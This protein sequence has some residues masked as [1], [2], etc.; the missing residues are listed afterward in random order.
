M[1]SVANSVANFQNELDSLNLRLTSKQ[2]HQNRTFSYK[3]NPSGVSETFWRKLSKVSIIW[4]DFSTSLR[5][6]LSIIKPNRTP[7]P[8]GPL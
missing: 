6:N 5:S 4:K 2:L 1:C 8:F 7:T 3:I